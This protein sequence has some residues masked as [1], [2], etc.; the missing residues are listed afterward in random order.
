MSRLEEYAACPFRF[1]LTSGLRVEERKLF[2]LDVRHQGSF[3]HE[4]LARFHQQ[5]KAEHKQWRD[6]TSA[7]ARARIEAIAA[8]LMPEYEGGLLQANEQTRFTIRSIVTALQDF[9]TTIIEWMPQYR[10]EPHA[11]ELAFGIEEKPMPAWE[12]DLGDGHR[13]SFRGKIDRVDLWR[14]PGDSAAWC[15]VMDYKSSARSLDAVLMAHG[16]A[17]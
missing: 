3:Q 10:F 1:A 6:I 13:L 5:L 8:S 17:I 9:I 11:V 16:L 2:R 7:D 12:M 14:Q 15:V 4:V